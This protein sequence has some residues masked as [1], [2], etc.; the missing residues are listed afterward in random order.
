MSLKMDIEIAASRVMIPGDETSE[1][2]LDHERG[3][4]MYEI[5]ILIKERAQRAS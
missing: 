5:S 2:R 1:G 4:L 3:A